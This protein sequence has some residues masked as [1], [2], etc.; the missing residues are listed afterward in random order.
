MCREPARPAGIFEHER[1]LSS[2]TQETRDRELLRSKSEKSRLRRESS[3][4]IRPPS[5]CTR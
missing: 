3:Q 2:G 5:S 1:Y 4:A